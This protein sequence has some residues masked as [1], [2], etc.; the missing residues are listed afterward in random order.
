M[1]WKRNTGIVLEE[2]AL[3][4]YLSIRDNIIFTA[5]LYGFKKPEAEKRTEE[6]LEFF[7]LKDKRDTLIIESS[8]GMRKKTAFAL[9]LIHNPKILFL[10][11]AFTGIDAVTIKRIKGLLYS[12]KKKGALVFISSHILD[13][14]E[15]IIDKCIIINNGSVILNTEISEIC[16]QGKTL[17]NVYTEI[18][19]G[20][21]V[22]GPVLSWF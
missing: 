14:I 19:A 8:H 11:E 20:K 15:P 18:I 12:L 10:D 22:P 7:N 16:K 21:S 13:S 17:E 3:F 6:I 5:E 9:S 1:E 4:E 2:L